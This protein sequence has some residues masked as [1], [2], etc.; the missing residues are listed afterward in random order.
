[1]SNHI[2]R[3]FVVLE[4]VGIP[5]QKPHIG[6]VVKLHVQAKPNHQGAD[7]KGWI[8]VMGLPGQGGMGM[9]ACLT[10]GSP[11]G[12]CHVILGGIF[13]DVGLQGVQCRKLVSQGCNLVLKVTLSCPSCPSSV[14]VPG[15]P[16][17][18]LFQFLLGD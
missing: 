1:M 4:D 11:L 3:P 2:H 17:F 14:D 6:L 5:P 16:H 10:P 12:I 18:L 7:R 15:H 9:I 8:L 13:I